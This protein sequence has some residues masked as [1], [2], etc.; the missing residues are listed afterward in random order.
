MA[1]NNEKSKGF[2]LLAYFNPA[3]CFT[4]PTRGLDCMQSMA[5]WEK[6]ASWNLRFYQTVNALKT[7]TWSCPRNA[8]T[9]RL[10]TDVGIPK[11]LVDASG[12]KIR[13]R[14]IA[15][16]DEADGLPPIMGE[17]FCSMGEGKGTPPGT[18]PVTILYCHGGAYSVGNPATH[19]QLLAELALMTGATVLA[20]EYR[21]CPENPYPAAQE[22]VKRAYRALL[23]SGVPASTIVLAGDSAGGGLVL[24][25]MLS[26]RDASVEMP[27]AA[28]L[29]SPWVDL[30]D[31]DSR[32]WAQNWKVDWLPKD[33]ARV[34]ARLYT[35][36]RDAA[37]PGI[38]PINADLAGLPP[39]LIE[40]G[41]REVLRDQ[42]Q[43]LATRATAAGVQVQDTASPDMVR[44][45]CFFLLH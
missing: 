42:I 13:R 39:M 15:P 20:V 19:R 37:T 44:V 45:A 17:A 28:V 22:D 8:H 4:A 24:S 25:T 6:P 29:L 34:A 23:S 2:G 38:S 41:E 27:A 10:F 16:A 7:A 26:L 9:V 40:S 12:V 5:I 30:C 21:R 43:R 31:F 14:E 32:S 18:Q 35:G 36:N 3:D 33:A 1:R 11:A